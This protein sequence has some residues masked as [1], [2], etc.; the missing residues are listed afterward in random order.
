MPIYEEAAGEATGRG[1]AW[2]KRA[3]RRPGFYWFWRTACTRRDWDESVF[4]RVSRNNRIIRSHR[5]DVRQRRRPPPDITRAR[6][7]R[8]GR[9][10]WWLDVQRQAQRHQHPH[11]QPPTRLFYPIPLLR[12]HGPD[13]VTGLLLL[14][15]TG[16]LP[17][18]DDSSVNCIRSGDGH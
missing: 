6:A 9:T 17:Y 13:W 16:R 10:V 8:D 2:K 18:H 3:F 1:H 4:G 11:P 12:Y 15:W 14:W 5:E 7:I